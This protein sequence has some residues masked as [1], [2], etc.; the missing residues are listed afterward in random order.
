[1]KERYP[2]FID[3]LK[4]LDDALCMAH[5]FATLPS[6]QR[7]KEKRV[8]RC[9]QLMMEWRNYVVMAHCL[10][11]VFLSI[12]GIYYQA[13][14]QGVKVTWLSPY[15]FSQKLPEDVD[16]EVMLT[17]LEFYETMLSF[18]HFKLYNS[19]GLHYPP[20]IDF[21][22]DQKDSGLYSLQIQYLP[23]LLNQ[24]EEDEDPSTEGAA[25]EQELKEVFS[26]V[27]MKR[28]EKEEE[29]KQF[30]NLFSKCIFFLSR[31]VP[32]DSLEFVIR[33][34]GGR[35]S[36][37]GGPFEESNE[38]ITHSI[39]DRDS[40]SHRYLS[41]DY[42]Q[43]QWV[44]DSVNAHF[45][46]PTEEYGIH[47]QLPPHLSPFVDDEVEGYI[48]ERREKIIQLIASGKRHSLTSQNI[49]R[50][51][52]ENEDSDEAENS[53]DE[54]AKS[55]E[56]FKKEFDKEAKGRKFKNKSEDQDEIKEKEE[57]DE[58]DEVEDQDEDEDSD[59]SDQKEDIEKKSLT[60][61]SKKRKTK[62][63]S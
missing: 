36:W 22:K 37:D 19:L 57:R 51:K 30:K 48:P 23:K 59:E 10:K 54:A 33:C 29:E 60:S 28:Y 45:L 63:R 3:A 32:R 46:L 56:R 49:D 61:K 25:T 4:D 2:S 47:V 12:R 20:S 31:E 39:V 8:K 53:E 55:E 40:Q 1:V 21:I 17:F 52:D 7:I 27:N 41:R 34:F 44:Y 18:V 42:V 43:P 58:K 62:R 5:L 38:S 26:D 35:V 13:E 6:D 16:Y 24:Q 15:Q 9:I 11:K 14:V 50:V